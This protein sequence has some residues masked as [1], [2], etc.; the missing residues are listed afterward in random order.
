M[1]AVG[2][3]D[4]ESRGCFRVVGVWGI[5]LAV[6]VAIWLWLAFSTGG[7]IPRQWL[8]PSMVVGLLG[9]VIS[10][11][12]AYPHRPPRHTFALIGLFACYAAWVAL[13]ALWAQSSTRVWL[14]SGRTFTYLL[15][16]TV[17][18]IYLAN[19]GA[20]VAFRYLVMGGAA[21]LLIV[22]IWKLWSTDDIALL[23]IENR[24]AFPVRYANN[25]AALFLVSL[26]PLMWLAASP[27]E[28]APVRGVALGLATGLLGLALMTQSRGAFWS[29]AFSVV[30]VFLVSP[31][32]LRTFLYL[33]VPAVLMVY[34]FPH[35]NRYW[36]EGPEAVGGGVGARAVLIAS[37]TAAFMGMILA[38]LERWI[39]VGRRT[40]T[41][42]GAVVL[43]GTLGAAVY[44]SIALTSDVG[45]PFKWVSQ[46]YREF[47]GEEPSQSESQ[48]STRLLV[49]SDSGRVGIWRVAWK[50]FESAPI[51]G[52]GAD[53][54]VFQY[55]RLRTTESY[56][57]QQAHSLVL[58]VL[59]ETGV[60]GAIFA[61]AG[62]LM[63]IGML[64]VPRFIVGWRHARATWLRR[65]TRQSPA[66][67]KASSS[68]FSP[69]WGACP[70][71]YGW[72]MALLAG[73][74]YWLI[75]A[76]VDWLWQMA[77]VSIPTLLFIA[78]GVAGMEARLDASCSL[79]GR[80]LR[81]GSDYEPD[82]T[83]SPPQIEPAA[84]TQPGDEV[85]AI[86]GDREGPP[87]NEDS[88]QSYRTVGLLSH[89]FRVFVAVI[90]VLVIIL[91]G[92][93]YLAQQLQDSALALASRDGVAAVKRAE[94]ARLFQP[95]DPS[96]YV[97]QASIYERSARDALE[98]D[99]P[100]RAGA[101]LDN[102][103]LAVSSYEKAADLEP[104]DWTLRYRAGVMSLNLLLA[105]DYLDGLSPQL[106]YSELISRIPGLGDWSRLRGLT[107][108][109]VP[110][111]QATG[112]LAAT[113]S[114]LQTAENLRALSAE[115]LASAA[116]N[117]LLA[118]KEQNPLA[119]ETGEALRAIQLVEE[120]R[121]SR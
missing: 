77:G 88:T 57:P 37:I 115:G 107:S 79:I 93:P 16:F 97:T 9:L 4:H 49:I 41:V 120:S 70:R 10:L 23:F 112:S 50:E 91:A 61:F 38:L 67:V 18:A 45:G 32:R 103:S 29:L 31:A 20:R 56:K 92:L 17:A 58:Q 11:A 19:R 7:Y 1:S 48:S 12:K 44:G 60:V 87:P 86:T 35:L 80:R 66:N 71:T 85:S 108:T 13:S 84:L 74:V 14:E 64:L 8:L 72:E 54:F 52:V 75:H 102:L 36:Q 30:F 105:R 15:V 95:A 90:S 111:G 51:L 42:L 25:A 22:C 114:A 69:L 40:K 59:G 5:P 117:R 6:V 106:D 62:T 47:T 21:V 28:H 116:T 109:V 98:S 43:L 99:E 118:A 100:D 78:A 101:V 3:S 24:L 26:W 104:A 89:S 2:S 94:R 68:W 83:A 96:P 34:V 27:E 55:D 119:S 76:S 73:A 33:I 113:P 65:K 53:N 46:T 110:A 81:V 82:E 121:S 63:A 39:R